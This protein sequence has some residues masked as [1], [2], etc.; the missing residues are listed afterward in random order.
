MDEVPFF[1]LGQL[2]QPTAYKKELSG[3]LEGFV[4]FWNVKR[5]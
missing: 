3:V 2:Y 5:G 4:L 1:P